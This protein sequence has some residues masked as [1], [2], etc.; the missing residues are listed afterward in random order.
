MSYPTSIFIDRKGNI[1][2]IRTGFY[3]PG[4]GEYYEKYTQETDAFVSELLK[5]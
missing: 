5:E 2:K 3:G 1:Q 4:T